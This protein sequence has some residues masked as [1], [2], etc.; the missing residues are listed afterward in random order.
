MSDKDKVSEMTPDERL[1]WYIETNMKPAFIQTFIDRRYGQGVYLADLGFT[2]ETEYLSFS[3]YLK[4]GIL[5]RMQ[6]PGN[7]GYD[8][9]A[10]KIWDAGQAKWVKQM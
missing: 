8:A 4:G 5:H 6:F 1:T 7:S 10:H 9:G 3:W 2:K